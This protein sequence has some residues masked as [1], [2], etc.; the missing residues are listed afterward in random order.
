MF[1][2]GSLESEDDEPTGADGTDMKLV[3]NTS[4]SGLQPAGN[5]RFIQDKTLRTQG[6]RTSCG[7]ILAHARKQVVA[8]REYIGIN[9]CVFKIG[10]TANPERRIQSYLDK[11]FSSMWLICVHEE[12]GLVHMLEAA[13]VAE[14]H[15]VSGCRNAAGSGGE[16]A[17][18]R[19]NRESP[20]YYVYITGGRADQFK[21][22]G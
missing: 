15:Q 3:S 7:K 16:G 18:N 6:P 17:L 21:K 14:F 20:P 11:N 5:Y 9:V 10:V 8:F 1:I 13:L 19:S 2:W 22:V 4:P 12:V